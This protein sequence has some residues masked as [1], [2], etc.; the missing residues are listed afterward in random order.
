MHG[1]KDM[2]SRCP[3]LDDFA[4]NGDLG[5]AAGK[6]DHGGSRRSRIGPAV[7]ERSESTIKDVK[8]NWDVNIDARVECSAWEMEHDS[9]DESKEG[10]EVLHDEEFI[11]EIP[12]WR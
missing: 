9:D 5:D 8:C 3:L 1:K 2:S 12:D 7:S 6:S 10:D 4:L 11:R